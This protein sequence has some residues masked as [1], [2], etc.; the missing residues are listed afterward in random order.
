MKHLI[1]GFLI[2]GIVIIYFGCT[3]NIPSG[4]EINPGSQITASLEKKI[5][6]YFNGT[7]TTLLPFLDPGKTIVLPNGKVMIRGLVVETDDEMDDPRVDGIVTWVVNLDVYTDGTD[8]RWGTGEL[9]IPD[10][11]RWIMPYK[12]WFTPQDGVTYEVDGHGKG[13]FRGLKA[14]W[15]YRKPIGAAEFTVNGYIIEKP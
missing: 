1:L 5:H 4:P 14:H 15:T 13:E 12:G 3:E 9:I 11:G 10:V 8:K 6:S 7:S 2:L